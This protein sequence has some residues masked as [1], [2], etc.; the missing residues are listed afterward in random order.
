MSAE[1][2]KNIYYKTRLNYTSDVRCV[3]SDDQLPHFTDNQMRFSTIF[4]N[5]KTPIDFL[6]IGRN[7]RRHSL[8]HCMVFVT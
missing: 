6:K 2:S 4:V 1:V 8:R 7:R 5:K 3:T